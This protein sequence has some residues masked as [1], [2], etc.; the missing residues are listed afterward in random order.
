MLKPSDGK[1]S[2]GLRLEGDDHSDHLVGLYSD[3]VIRG[4]G[5]HDVL[6]GGNG[7]DILFG[8][9]GSDVL[10]G[11]EG[12]DLLFGGDG[13]DVLIGDSGNDA[14]LAGEGN[15]LL[16]G[17]PG[18]DVLSGGRGADLFVFSKLADMGLGNRRDII[19]DFNGA[20]GDRIDLRGLAASSGLVGFTFIGDA[21]FTEKGQLR[22]EHGLLSGNVRG[23]LAPDF[24]IELIG[25]EHFTTA[26]LIL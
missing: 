5:G 20:M 22:F 6:E 25:V 23:G 14:L 19:T 12:G 21:P 26:Y 10:N 11:G 15:D 8:G 7:D 13:A 4:R 17:G 1:A 3:D 16:E 2:N 9:P 24:E 18:A